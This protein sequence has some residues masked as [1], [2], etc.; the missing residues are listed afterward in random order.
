MEEEFV[1]QPALTA[2]LYAQPAAGSAY[3]AI[4]QYSR[5]GPDTMASFRNS[6]ILLLVHLES[7]SMLKQRCRTWLHGDKNCAGLA[8]SWA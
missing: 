8:K 1:Q 4:S 2:P 6:Q 7:W 5:F 3:R